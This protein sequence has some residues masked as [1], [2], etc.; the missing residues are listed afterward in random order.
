VS[1]PVG[2][3]RSGP[4]SSIVRSTSL[5]LGA[6]VVG[7]LLALPLGWL[8]VKLADPPSVP[9]GDRGISYGETELNALAGVP[10]W[11]L[12]IGVVVGA[13]MGVWCALIGRR[14][15]WVVSL[16]VVVGTVVA[17]SVTRYMGTHWFS[18][19]VQSQ[20][21][22][23]R[24]GDAIQLDVRLGARA[25]LLVWSAAGLAGVVA[26]VALAWPR[27]EDDSHLGKA[28]ELDQ[29]TAVAETSG[30]SEPIVK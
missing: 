8:W 2:S 1:Q 15:G 5:V 21:H 23:A 12:V 17:A 22:G 24:R 9:M 26:V 10:G 7:A 20:L 16:A 18:P 4:G 6:A 13:A 19:D 25:L 29:A 14:L 28:A 3:A 27:L 11:F 30:P